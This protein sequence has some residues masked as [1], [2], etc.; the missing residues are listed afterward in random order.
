[1]MLASSMIA[2]KAAVATIVPVFLLDMTAPSF[3]SC[4]THMDV[5]ESPGVF[6]ADSHRGNAGSYVSSVIR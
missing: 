5:V 4:N 2:A 3:R 6:P 1:P